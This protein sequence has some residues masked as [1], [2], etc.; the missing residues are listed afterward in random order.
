MKNI[1]KL[2]ILSLLSC[3][4]ILSSTCAATKATK[5][6]SSAQEIIVTQDQ[7]PP[8]KANFDDQKIEQATLDQLNQLLDA[9]RDNKKKKAQQLIDAL[10]TEDLLNAQDRFGK[11][12]LM[13]AIIYNR[14]DLVD[15]LFENYADK[16][17]TTIK[18]KQ[19]Q[20][21]LD[22]ANAGSN[23]VDVVELVSRM[24]F[25]Q[26]KLN[27]L[28][29]LIRDQKK[30]KVDDFVKNNIT[31]EDL[32]AAKDK[33]GRTI[34]MYAAMYGN[35]DIMQSLFTKLSSGE[36]FDLDAK[37]KQGNT[38]LMYAAQYGNPDILALLREHKANPNIQNNEDQSA[39]A[40][41]VER[42]VGQQGIVIP[43]PTVTPEFSMTKKA[44]TTKD[45]YGDYVNAMGELLKFDVKGDDAR[46]MK[47]ILR[48]YAKRDRNINKLNNTFEMP[49][50]EAE[51]RV[52]ER[53]NEYIQVYP[54]I[55]SRS[56]RFCCYATA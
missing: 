42:I 22:H 41:I 4:T 47:T 24:A 39:L 40:A 26:P 6:S 51:K 53:I 18:D 7:V 31:V 11:T 28:L 12:I 9:I 29:N 54:P 55:F 14:K 25:A 37:D 33:A 2:Y 1:W 35:K 23:N 27:K 46:A 19:G 45:K 30:Q 50:A 32:N 49:G 5:K 3:G 38:A 20:T 13:Y 16:V 34:L 10:A 15:Y 56:L 48:D 8:L 21:A 43:W 44:L 36:H 52:K 17:D